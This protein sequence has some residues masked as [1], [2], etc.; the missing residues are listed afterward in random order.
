M[1][2]RKYDA[3]P[4]NVVSQTKGLKGI[5][6]RK[7]RKKKGFFMPVGLRRLCHAEESNRHGRRF[8][9]MLCSGLPSILL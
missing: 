2:R 7:K 9:P 3:F 1:F 6:N 4:K 5:K 8:Q